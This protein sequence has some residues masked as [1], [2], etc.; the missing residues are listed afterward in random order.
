MTPRWFKLDDQY[1]YHS[2]RGRLTYDLRNKNWIPH[3][4]I[5]NPSSCEADQKTKATKK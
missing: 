2:A 1:P 5:N 3:N 4:G